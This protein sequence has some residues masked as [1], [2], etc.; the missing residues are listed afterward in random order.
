MTIQAR[1]HAPRK[2]LNETFSI[3][4]S[5][6]TSG[7]VIDLSEGGLRFQTAS[8]FKNSES[9]KF[10]VESVQSSEAVA[11]LA[12]KDESRREGGLAFRSLPPEIH[13]VIRAWLDQSEAGSSARPVKVAS[14]PRAAAGEVATK[15]ASTA[16]T[17]AKTPA[18]ALHNQEI[19]KF[20]SLGVVSRPVQSN[21]DNS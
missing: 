21:E 13:K 2:L 15:S 4:F 12:W 19:S 14:L 6:G 9:V 3:R 10:R 5:P 1:R 11:D 18:I 17:L 20:G 8:P 7:V 16:A